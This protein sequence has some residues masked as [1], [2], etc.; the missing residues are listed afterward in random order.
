LVGTELEETLH[1]GE[2]GAATASGYGSQAAAPAHAECQPDRGRRRRPDHAFSPFFAST[3]VHCAYQR[4]WPTLAARLHPLP[5][6]IASFTSVTR[7][8]APAFRILVAAV[9]S[10]SASATFRAVIR[11]TI[12]VHWCCSGVCVSAGRLEQYP[13]T[14][15]L[16][17]DSLVSTRR[18][19]RYWILQWCVPSLRG[20]L[21][22]QWPRMI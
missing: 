22:V 14:L 1:C 19:Q 18:L 6:S 16:L 21:A 5:F 4:H 17:V 2:A 7:C 20:I 8:D 13:E 9:K 15:A 12:A 3:P 11:T 10:P